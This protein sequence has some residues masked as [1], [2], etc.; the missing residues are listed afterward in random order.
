VDALLERQDLAVEVLGASPAV[1]AFLL[2]GLQDRRAQL[3][4]HAVHRI[5]LGER[6]RRGKQVRPQELG[7]RLARERADAGQELE[8]HDPEAVEV[9]AA[10]Q[11]LARL[12]RAE[13][14]GRGVAELAE[15]DPRLRHLRRRVGDLGDPQVDQ[16]DQRPA[17]LAAADHHVVRRD[18]AMDHVLA[19]EVAERQQ[20]LVRDLES[21]RDPRRALHAEELRQVDPVDVLHD[22]IG[23]P[24][25]VEGEVQDLADVRVLEP[26]RRPRLLEEPAL[27]VLVGDGVGPHDLD[28]PDLVEQAVPDAVDRPHAALAQAVEDLVLSLEQGIE[29]LQANGPPAGPFRILVPWGNSY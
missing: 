12:E 23:G 16:L 28:D 29:L 19:V 5:G 27:Q 14:L 20:R 4:R 21:Q 11:P 1:L 8:H 3:R 22:E 25:V 10:V 26:G 6:D 7:R 2:E 13:L 18:V 9:A 15:K 17:V 24:L